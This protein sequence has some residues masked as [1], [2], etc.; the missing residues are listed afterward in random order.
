MRFLCSL[1]SSA[2]SFVMGCMFLVEERMFL[3]KGCMSYVEGY[4]KFQHKDT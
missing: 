4:N 2:M 1:R 3:D